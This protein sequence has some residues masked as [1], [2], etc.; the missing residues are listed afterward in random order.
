M[1]LTALLIYMNILINQPISF[2]FKPQ[3]IQQ[4]ATINI[5]GKIENVFPLFGPI[6]EMDWA[7]G[8]NPE[9]LYRSSDVLAEERMIFQ[10][11]GY[12]EKYIWVITQYQPDKHLIEYTVSAVERIWF[13]RVQCKAVDEKTEAT[14]SYTYTGLTEEG[15]QENER[16]L[17]RMFADSLSDWEEAINYYLKTGKLFTNH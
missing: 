15:N 8:W 2:D 5:D 13:I 9:I 10:T 11:Q 7:E 6:R 4:S 3:R 16:A 17:K 14:V 1:Q 12:G